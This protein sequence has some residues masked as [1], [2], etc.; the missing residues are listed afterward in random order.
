M[1][2]RNAVDSRQPCPSQPTK[3]ASAYIRV[4]GVLWDPV[5]SS[6]IRDDQRKKVR[7]QDSYTVSLA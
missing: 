3:D 7:W 6:V 5:R 1:I 4:G 2:L